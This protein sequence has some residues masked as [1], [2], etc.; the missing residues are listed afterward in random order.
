MATAL[1]IIYILFTGW[2]FTSILLYG[3]RPER[4][5]GWILIILILPFLGVILYMVFGINRKRFKFFNLN[6][7][8]KRQL[9]NLNHTSK[10]IEEFQHK[11]NAN[12]FTKLGTL[13]QQSSGFP[14]IDG[15][16]ITVYKKPK[17]V[18]DE[19]LTAIEKAEKFVHLLYYILEEGEMLDNLCQL[20]EKKVKEGVEVRI[21]YDALG[22]LYWSRKTIK[23]LKKTGVYVHPVLPLKL[24]TILSTLNYRNHRKIV[25]I[26][27]CI[28][29]SGG[30]NISDKYLKETSP[31]GIW[32][33][34][35][36]KI[37]GPAVDHLHRVFI[38]DYFFASKQKLLTKKK[39]L[40]MQK[41]AGDHLVQIITGGPDMKNSSIL[42]QYVMM[43]HSAE[44]S[45]YIE[46]PYFIP[47][48]V[49]LETIQ[50][51][52]LRGV[53]VKI[54]VPKNIDSR[55]AKYSMFSRFEGLLKKGINIYLLKDSFSHSK[56]IIVDGEIASIGSGNFDYR[57]FEH[58]YEVNTL[59]YDKNI[60][61]DLK[62]D[63]EEKI[64]DCKILNYET[65][66]NRPLQHKLIEGFSKIFSPL[67]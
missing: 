40:P 60:A 34:M 57:S 19:L 66:K 18:F 6:F 53:D 11:F 3:N 46:N 41:K 1:L 7:N 39:Y 4:S 25:I 23:R 32:D 15:N 45:V 33:D 27:G 67:L 50:M 30:I 61:E 8:A 54:M 55:I 10:N 22:S 17:E 9:Y 38:K 49:L 63:Y 21:L 43:V 13:M 16:Q 29:Y 52:T 24:G 20:F 65:F 62:K 2:A 28:A 58:N 14:A 5:M 47:N 44:K 56:L 12:K 37:I 64:K 36:L 26:D 35:H 51:A 48:R 59:I 42:H 31:L